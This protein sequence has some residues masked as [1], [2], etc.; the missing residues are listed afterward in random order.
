MPSRNRE[1]L[2]NYFAEG[3]LPTSDHFTDLI[4]SMLNMSDEGFSK[5][6]DNGV[7]V[8]TPVNHDALLS[9]FRDQA[10]KDA[11]WSIGYGGD[12]DELHFNAQSVLASQGTPP[13]LA[14]HRGPPPA[15]AAA[16]EGEPRSRVGINTATPRHALEVAGIVGSTGRAGTCPLPEGKAPRADGEW[17]ALTEPLSG[18]QAFEVV[19]GVGRPGFGRYAMMQ[20]VALNA[21]QPPRGWFDWLTGRNRIRAQHAWYG[22]RCDRLELGWIDEPGQSGKYRLCIRTRCNYEA[23]VIIQAHLTRLWFDPMMDGSKP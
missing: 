11:R 14:L 3:E 2:R 10:S 17:H 7:E 8:S 4:D 22:K 20:A 9:F 12:A 19:A 16:A 15:D 13:V 21:H 1:T 6:A 5:S 18:C 23:D